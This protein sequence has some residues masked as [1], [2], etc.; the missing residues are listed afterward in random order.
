MWRDMFKTQYAVQDGILYLKVEYS[1]GGV[2][3]APPRG[4]GAGE[5]R[6][7]EA[8][9]RYCRENGVAARLCAVSEELLALVRSMFPDASAVT[10]RSWS[11][12]LYDG[13]AI[14]TLAGRKYSGQRNHIN[15]FRREYPDWS[16]GTVTEAELGA[17]REFFVRYSAEHIKDYP[18]Y[19][20]GNVKT[21]ELI[22]NFGRYG[23]LGGV[24]RVGGEIVGASFGEVVGDT[25]FVHV[26]KANTDYPGA[27][28]M[29]V[30]QFASA[31]AVGGVMYINREEDDGVEG[32]R[33]S[34]LSYHPV[35]L[36]D[37]YVVELR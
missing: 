26:E 15:R 35:R 11:D 25:L 23:Q 4:D 27:Y 16:F 10:D 13:E 12:Y 7:Y 24:L 36:L 28:P 34:K 8:I 18:A 2:E 1:P 31:F 9:L 17:V 37:K 3:F 32:L 29:L 14:R 33:V 30:N 6:A 22:D 5:R 20:E 19:S 21:I